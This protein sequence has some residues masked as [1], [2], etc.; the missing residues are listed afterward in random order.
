MNPS[1]QTEHVPLAER[2]RRAE[3]AAHA[4]RAR[5]AEQ[6]RQHSFQ[7]TLLSARRTMVFSETLK[8]AMDSFDQFARSANKRMFPKIRQLVALGVKPTKNKE[9]PVRMTSYDIRPS[10]DMIVIEGEVE[11]VE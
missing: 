1:L 9:I 3:Q 10:D 6:A 8:L 7:Q 5:R 2:E 4:E 11:E